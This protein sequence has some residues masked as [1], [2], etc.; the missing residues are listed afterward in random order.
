MFGEVDNVVPSTESIDVMSMFQFPSM[1]YRSGG[2]HEPPDDEDSS[3]A[4]ADYLLA[5]FRAS[6]CDNLILDD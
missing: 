5:T 1:K 4:I 6:H 3:M 2:G